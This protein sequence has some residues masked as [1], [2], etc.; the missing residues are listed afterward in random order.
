M[1][2]TLFSPLTIAG[3]SHH[4][5][6]V[7]EMEKLRFQDDLEFLTL[8]REWFKGVVLLQTCNRVEIIVQGQADVLSE[9]LEHQGR[10]SFTMYR[11]AQALSHLLDLA[12]GIDYS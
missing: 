7:A 9:F 4:T 12:A 8:A 6:S 11:D 2:E 5:A 10:N 1:T 3:I